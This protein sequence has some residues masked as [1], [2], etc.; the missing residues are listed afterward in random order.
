MNKKTVVMSPGTEMLPL[1]VPDMPSPQTLMPWL[2]RMHVTKQ[3]SNFGPLVRELEASF[4]DRFEVSTGMLTTVAN[5]TLGL[6]LVMQALNLLP[7][8][9]VLVPAFT[10]V[11]SATAVIR[12]GYSPVLADVDPSTWMLTPA[13]ARKVCS[14]MKISAVLAVATFGMPYDIK[15][16][17]EFERET[18]IPVVIDAAAAY[19]SQWLG[20][21][22]GTLVFSLHATKSLPA[23]EGGLVV[24][25]RPGLAAK[26]RELA[27]FG[28]NLNSR[29][30]L[31]I[32]ALAGIGTNA[33]MSEY[34]AAIGL[35]SLQQWDARAEQRRQLETELKESLNT[36]TSG[37]LVWQASG[38]GGALK[39]PTLL[40]LRLPTSQSREVLEKYCI[41]SN[42]CLRRWYQPIL[43]RMDVLAAHCTTLHV[44]ESI[45][46]SNN[47]VGLPFFLEMNSLQ[48]KRLIEVVGNALS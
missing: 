9:R 21:N 44:P 43:S 17:D 32:G 3:Y 1:L 12:A 39:A 33:K 24:S 29:E 2:E 11:A 7:G 19:G 48:K 34:H 36:A 10:F 18:G 15:E 27:N 47:L 38:P 25:S 41:A 30:T 16:W 8:A 26:V 5:A 6:E 45:S 13:I 4:A 40:C 23:G 14:Q 35:A 42:I 31:P 46:L 37:R 28:I 20:E 22:E